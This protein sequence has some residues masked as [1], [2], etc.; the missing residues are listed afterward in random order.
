ML[1]V[2]K[3][4]AEYISNCRKKIRA[5]LAALDKLS[6]PEDFK[7]SYYNNLILVLDTMF[8]HRLRGLEGKD[9]NPMNEVRILAQSILINNTK[10]IE[11][12]TIHYNPE[13]SITK[14]KV[15]QSIRL[16]GKEFFH[17]SKAYLDAIE[18]TFS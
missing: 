10:L 14:V 2:K 15:E 4:K 1:G 5:D 17:L 8:A 12:K 3:Y 9:G 7:A 6:A 18:L 16:S 11:E 13:T